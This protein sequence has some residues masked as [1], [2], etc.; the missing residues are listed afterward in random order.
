MIR[1]LPL[2][3]V[4]AAPLTVCAGITLVRD[5]QPQAVVVV[6]DGLYKHVLKPAEQLTGDGMV[7]PLAAVE[8]ADYLS[9][10]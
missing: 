7:V 10:R 6:P 3:V 1:F 9:R 4:L 5:G 8:L 2:L